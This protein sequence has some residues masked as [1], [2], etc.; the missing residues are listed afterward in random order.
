ML[1]EVCQYIENSVAEYILGSILFHGYRP[2]SA[3]A[4]CLTLLERTGPLYDFYVTG[5][6]D[7]PIQVLCRSASYDQALSDARSVVDLLCGTD[8]AGITLPVLTS[9]EAWVIN[10]AQVISGPAW[11][12]QDTLN[13]HEF[14]ANIL[15][16]SQ[17]N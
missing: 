10:T 8:R 12:G 1:R 15:L 9:G 6:Q 4:R 7:I 5:K 3:P 2:P 16:H 17:L 14:T 11:L 13:R